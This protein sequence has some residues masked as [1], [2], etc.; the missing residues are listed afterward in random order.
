MNSAAISSPFARLRNPSVLPGF[1]LTL[2]FTLFYLSAIVLI[3]LC[4]L[5]LKPWS[6]GWDGFITAITDERV[7][8]ALKLSFGGAAIAAV[9]NAIFGTLVAWTLVRYRFP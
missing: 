5:L 2:G 8:A 6:L 3:P 9:V 4:A 7:V 1:G